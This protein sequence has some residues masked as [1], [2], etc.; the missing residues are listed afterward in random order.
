MSEHN[1]V[2]RHPNIPRVGIACED[3]NC[4]MQK[5][6][7]K[8]KIYGQKMNKQITCGGGKGSKGVVLAA[9]IT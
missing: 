8:E 7:D 4:P 3:R 6:K 9:S 1:N 2:S 5:N